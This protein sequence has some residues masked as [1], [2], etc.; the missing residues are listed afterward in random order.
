[1]AIHGRRLRHRRHRDEGERGAPHPEPQQHHA[2]EARGDGP[3][4]SQPQAE[5]RNG[6]RQMARTEGPAPFPIGIAGV[7]QHVE[8]GDQRRHQGRAARASSD[9]DETDWCQRE[10]RRDRQ[11][12]SIIAEQDRRKTDHTGQIEPEPPLLHPL[13]A[14]L[15]AVCQVKRRSEAR[16][17][18]GHQ[19]RGA[20]ESAQGE[21]RHGA[22]AL[23]AEGPG[24][25]TRPER[26]HHGRNRR[27]KL[28][29]RCPS[30]AHPGC[31]GQLQVGSQVAFASDAGGRREGEQQAGGRHSVPDEERRERPHRRRQ[32]ECGRGEQGTAHARAELNRE[33][34]QHDA[35]KRG[36]QADGQHR[37][38]IRE[39]RE[40]G[41]RFRV[42]AGRQQGQ[43][44]RFGDRDGGQRQAGRF[45]R[46]VMPVVQRL[47]TGVPLVGIDADGMVVRHRAH[48]VEARVLIPAARLVEI[49][50]RRE[51]QREDGGAHAGI[52]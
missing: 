37:G 52:Q 42:T 31:G 45:V 8:H 38:E 9:D 1:M 41:E 25:A 4:A 26:D 19:Y 7:E 51:Q 36:E 23:P 20:R 18:V 15:A 13:E 5:E 11:Q 33:V 21:R 6:G 50:V 34:V 22:Q 12:P 2:T 48:Q 46:V 44:S 39:D 16:V 30:G 3:Q 32:A 49:R 24:A 29:D 27:G 28:R 14:F 47:V 35:G 40:A 10:D 17:L 43:A